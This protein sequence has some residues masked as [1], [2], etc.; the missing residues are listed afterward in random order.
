MAGIRPMMYKS[1][2]RGLGP[3]GMH[4]GSGQLQGLG[5][6]LAVTQTQSTGLAARAGPGL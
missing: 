5:W 1:T 2:A 6:H 4:N 3:N